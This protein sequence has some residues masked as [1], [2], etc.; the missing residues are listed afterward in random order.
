MWVWVVLTCRAVLLLVGVAGEAVSGS[1]TT[2]LL[3]RMLRTL[4]T[5][6]PTLQVLPAMLALLPLAQGCVRHSTSTRLITSSRGC[7]R[8]SNSWWNSSA[9]CVQCVV[10]MNDKHAIGSDLAKL[11]RTTQP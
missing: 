6:A 10:C 8:D 11:I 9:L 2:L 4:C 5:L 7:F 1:M 3:L